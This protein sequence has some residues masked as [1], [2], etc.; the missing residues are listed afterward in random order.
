MRANGV[1]SSSNQ[2]IQALFSFETA[3]HKTEE[4]ALLDSGASHNF[5][6]ICTIWRLGIG[7]KRLD[8]PRQVMNVDGTTNKAGDISKYTNLT[9]TYKD[10]MATLPFFVTNLR[11]D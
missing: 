2:T 5:I 7:T 10:R 1:T 9:I 11:K 3:K 6:D 8:E 4:R